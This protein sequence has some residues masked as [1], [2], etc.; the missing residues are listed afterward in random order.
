MI[1]HGNRRLLKSL[2]LL[3]LAAEAR[4]PFT[5]G[6]LW[7]MS[8]ICKLLADRLG[9]SRR[10]AVEATVG[11]WLH[12]IGKI[13]IA[14]AILLKRGRLDDDEM[15]VMRRHPA[16]GAAL[17]REHPLGRLARR[18]VIEHHERLDG[19]GYPAG[20]QGDEIG[21]ASR[22][23]AVADSFDAMTSVRPYRNPMPMDEALDRLRPL[24]GRQY[25]AAA[26][27][28]LDALAAEGAL[29]GIVGHSDHGSLLVLCPHCGPTIAVPMDAAA[30]DAVRCS[31]CLGAFRLA[32][33]EDDGIWRAEPATVEPEREVVVPPLPIESVIEAMRYSRPS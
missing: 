33:G 21:T 27:E 13:A 19:S 10:I 30:G 12:D 6:H 32:P 4:D 9:T 22:I 16:A 3:G 2:L 8:Q 14:D 26:F 17:L 31:A 7:R 18:S 24:A 20:L 29:D 28:A 1:S 5:A 15:R 25:D 11:G 23:V